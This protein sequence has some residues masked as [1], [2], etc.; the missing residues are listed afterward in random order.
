MSRRRHMKDS[1]QLHM[2][3]GYR[4]LLQWTPVN[5][6]NMEVAINAGFINETKET[7]GINHLLEHVLTEA[8]SKCGTN[9]SGY[10]ADKG[11]DMNASTSETVLRY[12]TRGTLMYVNEMIEYITSISTHPI[13]KLKTLKKEKEAV[14]DELLT[15][16]NDPESKLDH[17][18][19][20]RFYTGGLVFKDD[21]KLQINN[22]KH[23][24]LADV[25]KAYEKNY[26]P[27]NLVFIVTGNVTPRHVL[28]IFKR[29][30]QKKIPGTVHA[31]VKSCFT[32]RHEILYSKVDSPTTKILIG[33][34]S[35]ISAHDESA[36]Y[37]N[38]VCTILNDIL[39]AKLRTELTLVY[40]VRFRYSLNI[41]GNSTLCSIYVRD[42]HIVECLR[43]LFSSLNHFAKHPF[44]EERLFAAMQRE[45]YNYQMNL[46]YT[47][48]YLMQYVHQLNEK[49]PVVRSRKEKIDLLSKVTP[50]TLMRVFTQMY[51][52]NQCL[53][54][55]QGK[56]NLSL[57]WDQVL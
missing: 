1:V 56:T 47:K 2:V 21:W 4:V 25:R 53:L 17:V 45:L 35:L 24:N 57:Q 23:L 32:A 20:A 29:E 10:W 11:V 42:Q 36:L 26:N 49:K 14:I 27:G 22:L 39:F 31:Q 50:A 15:Y 34:P 28:P 12:H 30:L 33:F 37:L 13:M 18:F 52:L 9:C 5:T 55:Y 7:S 44:P 48:D 41:C 43:A 38:M 54:V 19:N 40:G 51:N 3:E 8:W 6:I 46:P 16:G